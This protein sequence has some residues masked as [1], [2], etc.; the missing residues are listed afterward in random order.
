MHKGNQLWDVFWCLIHVVPV[1]Y[2]YLWKTQ[3]LWKYTSYESWSFISYLNIY[4]IFP[5]IIHVEVSY[6]W[7][8]C[9][10][11]KCIVY[12]FSKLM[13]LKRIF[14]NVFFSTVLTRC[15]YIVWR[16]FFLSQVLWWQDDF[17]LCPIRF[18]FH[19]FLSFINGS[20]LKRCI[21]IYLSVI[22]VVHPIITG[23]FK[24]LWW[25]CVSPFSNVMLH[26]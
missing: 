15:E 17:F 8:M 19:N 12:I 14:K 1:A 21:Q 25:N 13:F 18:C 10:I 23:S 26:Y 2:F 7:A 20:L 4:Q 9:Q 24:S 3:A 6:W 16:L 11:H 5:H 22:I